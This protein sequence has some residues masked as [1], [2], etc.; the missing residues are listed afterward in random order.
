MIECDRDTQGEGER[1]E[2]QKYK[3]VEGGGGGVLVHN[4]T[5]WHHG[6][7]DAMDKTRHQR[8]DLVG[9]RRLINALRS[10]V[11]RNGH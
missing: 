2:G 3:G 5:A 8:G 11:T 10:I 4:P 7:E 9:L 1:Q 6:P